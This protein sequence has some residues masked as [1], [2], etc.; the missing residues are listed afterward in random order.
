MR[1]GEIGRILP[2][3]KQGQSNP[4]SFR[5]DNSEAGLSAVQGR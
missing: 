4:P 5:K 1:D 3:F 2:F